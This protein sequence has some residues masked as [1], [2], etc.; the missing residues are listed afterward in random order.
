MLGIDIGS[1]NIKICKA[2]KGS[3]GVYDIL[4]VMLDIPQA[5]NDK[6]HDKVVSSVIK[7]TIKEKGF[8]DKNA[9]VAIGNSE[10]I[11]RKLD[12]P[13]MPREELDNT[14]R[15]Q[16]ER[17]IYSDLNEMDIDYYV[18][19]KSDNSGMNVIFVAVPKG[20]V[21]RQMRL[22]QNSGLEP[23]IMDIDNMAMSNCF[24]AFG[25]NPSEGTVLLMNI[26][27]SKT[28][29]TVFDRGS[30]CFTRNVQFGGKDIG[31][32]IG[33][34]LEIPLEKAEELKMNPSEWTEL[35][36]NMKNV[37][38]KCSPD[39]LEAVYRSIEYCKSQQL[40]T[41]IDKILLTGGVACLQEID[42]FF[43]G[44]LGV[45]TIVW[46]P[47]SSIGTAENKDRGYF[48]GIALGLAIRDINALNNI[49]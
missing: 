21:D 38:R 16:A 3:N 11:V 31:I 46:D 36:L 15:L 40:I 28:C 4:T 48:M 32:A 7:T 34:E 42:E 5:S 19:E 24:L 22:I 49:K 29:F 41:R 12:F 39:L 1:K 20:I 37:L 30:F 27:H 17:F 35:G 9:V 25:E 18:E 33:N 2:D 10:I 8:N 43:S 45:D 6:E 26:G 44:I 13:S 23:V 14:V 47:F